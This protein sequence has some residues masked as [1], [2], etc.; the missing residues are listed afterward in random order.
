MELVTTFITGPLFRMLLQAI[1]G[2]IISQGWGDESWLEPAIGFTV[3]VTA[4]TWS[5][6]VFLNSKKALKEKN[7][8]IEAVAASPV[9]TKQ[10]IAEVDEVNSARDIKEIAKK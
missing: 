6:I 9:A 7:K 10:V 8:I 3:N 4:A 2:A 1:G 5:F